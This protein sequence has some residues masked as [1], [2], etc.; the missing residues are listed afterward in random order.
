M[1]FEDVLEK[2]NY[3]IVKDRKDKLI[4]IRNDKHELLTE[5]YFRIKKLQHKVVITG[6]F[7]LQEDEYEAAKKVMLLYGSTFKFKLSI[8]KNKLFYKL[9][10]DED[11][12]EPRVKSILEDLR[13]IKDLITGFKNMKIHLK[14]KLFQDL[15]KYD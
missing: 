2:C 1:L 15:E 10:T 8:I 11:I 13:H 5:M 9:E 6:Y 14:T 7:E 4:E 3:T 12:N